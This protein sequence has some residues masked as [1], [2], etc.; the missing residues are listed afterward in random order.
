MGKTSRSALR[1]A[2]KCCAFNRSFRSHVVVGLPQHVS[3]RIATT[4]PML[5]LIPRLCATTFLLAA[6]AAQTPPLAPEA[7]AEVGVSLEGKLQALLDGWRA[8]AGFPGA[9]F[10]LVL[11]DGTILSLA[12]GS[13]DREAK[14][15]MPVHARMLAGSIGKTFVAA[16]ALQLVAAK[17]LD[18]DLEVRH[19]LKDAS[20]FKRL[21]N[22]ESMHVRHL[23]NHTSGLVRY[24]L[25]EGFLTAFRAAPF[26]KW[27][28]EEQLAFLFDTPAPFAPG[29]GWDYSDTNYLVLGEIVDRLLERPRELAIEELLLKPLKLGHTAAQRGPLVA[30]LVQGY[31]GA[32]QPFGS[33]DAVQDE[34]GRL[35][36]DPSFEGAGGGYVSNAVDLAHWVRHYFEGRAFDPALLPQVIEGPA[37]PMLGRGVRYGLGAILREHAELGP[38]R[39]HSG[40]FPG[41]LSEMAYYADYGIGAAM[42]INTSDFKNVRR[43]LSRMLDQLV[44]CAIER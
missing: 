6:L 43:P 2:A 4:H 39:G 24:E 21:P 11:R 18:L 44:A 27:K 5:K 41:Y 14:V 7:K 28:V 16:L 8:D 35:Y 33:F 9:T 37:A 22:A 32:K 23:M 42:Q 15:A 29:E 38:V 19:Y 1:M 25:G 20:W 30:G 3:P 17:K 26:R 36:F 40:Y 34:D 12:T 31:A 10:T 13:I